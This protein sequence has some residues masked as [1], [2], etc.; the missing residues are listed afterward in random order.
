MIGVNHLPFVVAHGVFGPFDELLAP[1]LLGALIGLIAITWWN[2]R[3]AP[4]EPP[5]VS[6]EVPAEPAEPTVPVPDEDK[7]SHYSI[8]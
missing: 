7:V 1:V 6:P 3:K 4:V 5:P 2:G 8:H